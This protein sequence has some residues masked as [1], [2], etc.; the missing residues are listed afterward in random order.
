MSLA[1]FVTAAATLVIR[2]FPERMIRAVDSVLGFD[3]DRAGGALNALIGDC[4]DAAS[5]TVQARS[6]SCAARR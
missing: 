6:H 1:L 5:P 3:S 4:R 2:M